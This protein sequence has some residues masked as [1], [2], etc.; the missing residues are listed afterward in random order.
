[1]YN[2]KYTEI[3]HTSLDVAV[4]VLA[5]AFENA[6]LIRYLL[7]HQGSMYYSQIREFFRFTCETRL[8]LGWPLIGTLSNTQLTG[9]ACISVPENKDWPTSLVKKYEKL[10]SFIGTESVSRLERF[11]N[12]SNHYT[13]RQPHY[14][15]SAIGIHP[16]F[17]GR[18]FGRVLLD[19]VHEMSELHPASTG[20][21]LE[22]ANPVNVPFYEHFGYHLVSKDKLD[23]IVDLWYMF[24]PNDA[25]N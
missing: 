5:L 1:M 8:D 23:D 16:N 7:P 10:M 11:S 17:Q 4:E 19:T 13:L 25:Q 22:T 12:L 15:L 14:Y 24:R 21:Y 2:A 3:F 20:V 18:G 9:V 6:P